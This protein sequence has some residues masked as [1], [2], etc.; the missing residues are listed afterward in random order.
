MDFKLDTILWLDIQVDMKNIKQFD[1]SKTRKNFMQE[2]EMEQHFD[3]N[4]KDE[5]FCDDKMDN[6]A[7]NI[8]DSKYGKVSVEN[9]AAMQKHLTPEQQAKLCDVL[10]KHKVFFDGK[11]GKYPHEKFHLDLIDGAEPVHSKPY[12]IPY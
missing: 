10:K 4:V 11:L 3:F 2:F 8:L 12:G 9:N 5:Y 6:Y 1:Q 7:S